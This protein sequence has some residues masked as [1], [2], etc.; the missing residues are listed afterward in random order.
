[1]SKPR[2]LSVW[3]KFPL[4][5]EMP[6]GKVAILMGAGRGIRKVMTECKILNPMNNRGRA[7]RK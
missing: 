4:C 7:M 6:Y 3:I 1:M 2:I 5:L